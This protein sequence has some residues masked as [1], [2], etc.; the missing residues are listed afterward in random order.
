MCCLCFKANFILT[1]DF[2]VAA[3]MAFSG[4]KDSVLVV[5]MEQLTKDLFEAFSRL[6]HVVDEDT[7]KGQ[8]PVCFF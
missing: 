8:E 2:N 5:E 7:L 4:L 6:K 3:A 1:T